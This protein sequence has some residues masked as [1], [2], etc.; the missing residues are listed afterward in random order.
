MLLSHP[1]LAAYKVAQI[2]MFHV[3][4]DHQGQ[5]FLWQ[6]D[7]QQRKHIGVVETLHYDALL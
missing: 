7:A 4:Q 3:W 1:L 6:E 5:P 2:P